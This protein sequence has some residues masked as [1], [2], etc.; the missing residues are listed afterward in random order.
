MK[1][2]LYCVLS[3][4]LLL[5]CMSPNS[6]TDHEVSTGSISG[7]VVCEKDSL[8]SEVVVELYKGDSLPSG[9]GKAAKKSDSF[10]KR[11]TT[12]D[13]TYEFKNLPEGTYS[14][15]VLQDSLVI[16]KKE[17]VFLKQDERLANVNITVVIIIQQTFIIN[18]DNSRHITINNFF[19]NN[20]RI[21][22]DSAGKY[23][24][25]FAGKDTLPVIIEYVQNGL[26]KTLHAYLI[27]NADGSY[28]IVVI[29]DSIP[30]IIIILP[31][32]G[33]NNPYGR[34]LGF[35]VRKDGKSAEHA[36]VYAR[37]QTAADNS[38]TNSTAGLKRNDST[39]VTAAGYFEFDSLDTGKY[40]VELNDH[41]TAG[42]L[43]SAEITKAKPVCIF[44]TVVLAGFG[45]IMG[46]L[47]DSLLCKDSMHV[48]IPSLNRL[49]YVNSKSVFTGTRIPVG[50]YTLHLLCGTKMVATSLDTMHLKV[51]PGDTAVPPGFGLNKAP[52]F[53][54]TSTQMAALIKAGELYKDTVHAVDP[55]RDTLRFSFIDNA[56]G[57]TLS[58]SIV[59]WTPA[60]KDTGSHDVIVL[61]IDGKGGM[62][63]LKWT[64]VVREII[65]PDTGLKKGL[66]AY[67]PFNGNAKDESGNGNDGTV[68]GPTLTEDRFH[69][70]NKA[71]SFESSATNGITIANATSLNPSKELTITVWINQE[72]TDGDRQSVIL[73]KHSLYNTA[74]D[75]YLLNCGPYPSFFISENSNDLYA[76]SS[77]VKV[78][79]NSGWHFIT[80]V[81]K[82]GEKLDIYKDGNNINDTILY[83]CLNSATCQPTQYIPLSIAATST[84]VR[85]GSWGNSTHGFIGKIDDLRIYNRALSS[86]EIDSLFH[87]GGWTGNPNR[88]PS[89]TSTPSDMRDSA[90]V[91]AAYLDTLHA[92][93]PDGDPLTFSFLGTSF[94]MTLRDSIV[95][96]TPAAADTGAHT[97]KATVS[98]KK[99]GYDTLSW[100]I[101]VAKSIQ[102]NNP[103]HFT[104]TSGELTASAKAGTK[105]TDTVHAVDADND[106][107]TYTFK[108]SVAGMQLKDSVIS[109]I[110]AAADTGVKSICALAKDGKGGIDSLKWTIRVLS[111][112]NP[113]PKWPEVGYDSLVSGEINPQLE[114]DRYQFQGVAGD[115]VDF[116]MSLSGTLAA[117]VTILDSADSVVAWKNGG[118]GGTILIDD[119][120]L[121]KTETYTVRIKSIDGS[122]SGAY[123][124]LL[125]SRKKLIDESQGVP[126]EQSIS[127]SIDNMLEMN[128]YHFQGTA[129][130]KI[131]FRMA[132][133]GSLAAD[134]TILDPADSIVAWKNGG[135]GGTILIDDVILP[136][137]ETYIIRIKS[138]SGSYNGSYSF[139]L[140]SREK[141]IDE[142]QVILFE[143]SISDSINNTLEMNYYNFQGTAGDK[144]SFRMSLSGTL[145]ADVTILDPADSTV[146]WK[147]GGMGGTILIDDIVLL[148]T[149]KY[150][151]R[152]KSISGVYSGAYTIL[153]TKN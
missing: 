87:E 101:K 62:D 18:V 99:G 153:L 142:S 79:P 53:T 138:I 124:F 50:V 128:Y 75:S 35:A 52:Y 82:S 26:A 91:G 57:M 66:V 42:A 135:L 25:T 7:K 137:T 54:S 80:A 96:W 111:D 136:K 140:Y 48:F 19:I 47:P 85:I 1:T 20:S 29:D 37:Y 34:I 27:R 117:D 123:S 143:Q 129:G 70:S 16:G 23:P 150:T 59:R 67:Y 63:T 56:Q 108:D 122:Y 110:P 146:A 132:L 78:E 21:V 5:Y 33:E 36:K 74:S 43:V 114:V 133:S 116:R 94:G 58:D 13:L 125:Y 11:D 17:G 64:I 139:L 77:S 28:R 14:M 65:V 44:P 98:D 51:E 112:S 72:K 31:D 113:P 32:T 107:I 49:L 60:A 69:Q 88:A 131:N 97:I 83:H 22:P 81:F 147:N 39:A 145:A 40:A 55:D 6:G 149:E 30:I 127:D 151:I 92:T 93:D 86:A 95:Q 46:K 3:L 84:P 105:Y 148:K 130:D 100:M 103:P 109:W 152:L 102:T 104:S 106:K 10:L 61:V 141:L 118:L 41:D 24:S 76:M 2:A 71:Y 73:S 134:I 119:V 4:C 115:K 126:F 68:N 121:P 45:T 12:E 9:L 144:I 38:Q 8:K 15:R 90:T 89:F 120:I